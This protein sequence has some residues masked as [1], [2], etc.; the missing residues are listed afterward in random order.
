MHNEMCVGKNPSLNLYSVSAHLT[1][2]AYF[3]SFCP[4]CTCLSAGICHKGKVWD[5]PLPSVKPAQKVSASRFSDL[6][7][8]TSTKHPLST[9]GAWLL[10]HTET[11][12]NNTPCPSFKDGTVSQ[13][14]RKED[15][16]RTALCVQQKTHFGDRLK[17]HHSWLHS[18]CPIKPKHF[19][20]W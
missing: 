1:H 12:S 9:Q 10:E 8:L 7:S 13:C 14:A 11:R 17:L 20:Q 5:F 15:R 16:N 3:I 19:R 2:R 6:R 4:L 18:S